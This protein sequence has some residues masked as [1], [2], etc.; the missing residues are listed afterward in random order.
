MH[1]VVLEQVDHVVE[2][3]EG[4][5]DGDH[6]S[7]VASLKSTSEGEATNSSKSIDSKLND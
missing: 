5:V 2:V 4:V 1:G 7:H 6:L 3:H